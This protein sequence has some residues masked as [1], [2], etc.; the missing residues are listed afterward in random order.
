LI[1]GRFETQLPAAREF[2][3]ERIRRNDGGED[4]DWFRDVGLT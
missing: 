4:A 2:G 1:A 3:G